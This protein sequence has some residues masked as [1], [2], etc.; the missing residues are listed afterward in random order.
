M[1]D[2]TEPEP[3]DAEFE[4][5]DDSAAPETPRKSGGIGGYFLTFVLSVLIGGGMGGWIAWTLD[6][7]DDAAGLETR[8]AALEAMPSPAVFDASALEAR[9]ADLEST[10]PNL[11]SLQT[12]LDELEAALSASGNDPTLPI[13]VIALENSVQQNEALANQALD[14]I[15]E[16]SGGFNTEA[17]E[18][19]IAALEARNET[20]SNAG[21]LT[22]IEARLEAL[23]N[24]EPTGSVDLSTVTNRLDALEEIAQPDMTEVEARLATVENRLNATPMPDAQTSRNAGHVAREALAL[25]TLAEAVNSGQAYSDQLENFERFATADTGIIG[26]HAE[27]GIMTIPMLAR[28]FPAEAILATHESERVFFGLIEVSSSSADA[29]RLREQIPLIEERLSLG[30]LTG[31]I[32]LTRQLSTDAQAAASDWQEAAMARQLAD[33]RLNTIRTSLWLRQ[34]DTEVDP[35]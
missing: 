29:R 12:R 22:D 33:A 18:A 26:Q 17:I 35:T 24:A 9:L 34:I 30:D 6:G 7:P 31:A 19:R 10:S 8:I 23:E 32:L 1:N 14:Q 5:A 25:M 2:P 4:P 13:R 28:A 11:E 21:D 15:G 27:T 16:M 3:L 20:A